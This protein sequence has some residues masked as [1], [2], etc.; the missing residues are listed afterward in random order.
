MADRE[1]WVNG[2]LVAL[3]LAGVTVADATDEIYY[4]NLASRIVIIAMAGVGL[5]LALGYG[6][7]ISFGHA[8]FFGLG[9]Y[10]AGIAA[11]HAFE[12]TLFAGILPGSNQMLVIWP[13]AVLVSGL[14]ALL[15]GAISLRTQ[16]V[17]FIM[18]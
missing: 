4:V 7:M 11:F 18:I 12:E 5:N 14:A 2:G 10:A 17:Y 1:A 6:G 8:A 15:I 16:G 3:L 9:G 13:I